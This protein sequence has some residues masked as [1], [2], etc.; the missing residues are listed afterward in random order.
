MIVNKLA[1]QMLLQTR[2]LMK[3]S[4]G[5]HHHVYDWRDDHAKNPDLYVDER[6]FGVK[7]A[8]EYEFPYKADKPLTW[9]Y[10]HPEDY[11]QKDLATNMV[12]SLGYTGVLSRIDVKKNNNTGPA[13]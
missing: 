12:G 13:N 1:S 2:V 5:H 9:R 6:M 4:G 10:S 11:N 7:P 3:F 8:S